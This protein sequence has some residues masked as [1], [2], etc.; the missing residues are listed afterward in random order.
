LASILFEEILSFFAFFCQF[1][2]N[3]PFLS[4]LYMAGGAEASYK[5]LW[6]QKMIYV[7]DYELKLHPKISPPFSQSMFAQ[8]LRFWL[9]FKQLRTFGEAVSR[10]RPAGGPTK[11]FDRSHTTFTH[12]NL[13]L[14][15][16][17]GPKGSSQ[18]K[19][20]PPENDHF[21]GGWK[22]KCYCIPALILAVYC[23]VLLLKIKVV[24]LFWIKMWKSC[25]IFFI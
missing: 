10:R 4:V 7:M 18:K 16:Y 1:W 11:N 25:I 12:P 23:H 8:N 22:L 20:T 24:I 13:M 9:I 15:W 19:F 2:R 21:Q 6:T 17:D 5:S 14:G 3:V